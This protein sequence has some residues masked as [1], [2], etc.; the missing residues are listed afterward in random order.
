[1]QRA[2]Q[3]RRELDQRLVEAQAAIREH[4]GEKKRAL[5]QNKRDLE[6]HKGLLEAQ[7]A[8]LALE[9]SSTAQVD[10]DAIAGL[11]ASVLTLEGE[12]GALRQCLEGEKREL[13]QQLGAAAQ[14]VAASDAAYTGLQLQLRAAENAATASD[15]ANTGLQLQLRAAENAATASDAANTG[16][17][18][19]LRAA[20]N[21]A[22]ASDAANTGLQLQLLAAENA[23]TAS[24][25]AY[26]G[27]QLQLRAAENAATASLVA[28]RSD[29]QQL[30]RQLLDGAGSGGRKRRKQDGNYEGASGGQ[31]DEGCVPLP[32]HE[33]GVVRHLA[34]R[35]AVLPLGELQPWISGC[36]ADLGRERVELN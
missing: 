36:L 35:V 30:L 29:K 14:R 19:Q 26:T 3:S 11:K 25:A 20:E 4:E 18:L 12:S 16:L 2:L 6:Q 33:E 8:V 32:L 1:M 34:E 28:G 9:I 23:A 15:A 21:A 5:L 24:D 22:T 17:Q 31:G 13:Q 10:A 27:L 7:N